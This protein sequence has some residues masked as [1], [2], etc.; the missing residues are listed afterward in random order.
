MKTLKIAAGI[1]VGLVFLFSGIVK[2]IDPLGTVYKFQDYFQAFGLNSM[3]F[4]AFPSAFI[5]FTAEFLGGFSVL[6]GIMKK[7]GII[8]VMI[9]MVIFTPLTLI[10]AITNP[11]TDC[12]CFGDAIHLSNWQ[13]FGKNVILLVP[14]VFL[15]IKR[16]EPGKNLERRNSLLI[17]SCAALLLILFA[18]YNLRYLPVVDFLPYKKGVRIADKMIIPEG[19]TPDKYE[20]TF[21]YEKKGE[22]KEFTLLNYPA[23][24]SSWT[25]V[26]QKSVL[27]EKGYEPPIHDFTITSQEGEDIT[28]K[29]LSH[30]GYSLLM[31]TK[32]FSEAG[33]KHLLDGFELGRYCLNKG[34]DFYVLTASGKDEVFE[35]ENGVAICSADE[36]T[37]KTMVR[38]N[39]GYMLLKDGVITG[40]WSWAGVPGKEWF[41]KLTDSDIQR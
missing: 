22:R 36:T 17:M 33:E 32:K 31:V 5:L 34:I 15:F 6:T 25:F 41:G 13:T 16:N 18:I 9:L 14:A 37:L 27:I 30:T 1:I 8:V 10:L 7:T 28:P 2:A 39:P 19:A 35:Y 21:I 29:I 12:G 38:S 23:N 40:K 20:T 4:L 11:V 3:K 24:D 26:E